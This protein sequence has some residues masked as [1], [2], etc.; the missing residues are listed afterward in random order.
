MMRILL[1]K[2]KLYTEMLV[3]QAIIRHPKR[4]LGFYAIENP[5]VLQ[6]GGSCPDELLHAARLAQDFGYDEINLNLGC[7]SPRVQAGRFGACLMKEK[8][9]VLQCLSH[10]KDHLDIPVTAKT[11][12]GVDECDSYG[13]FEDF[14]DGLV[15]SG[16]DELVVHARK[17]WLKGLNPKQNRIIPPIDYDF[18]YRIKQKHPS[19]PMIING[20]LKTVE[21]MQ[22]QLNY[23]DG[24]MIG[25]LACDNPMLLQR[26]H[27]ILYPHIDLPSRSD[28]LKFYFL[29]ISQEKAHQHSLS[30][31]LKP[32]FNLYHGTIYAK[33]WRQVLQ[34]AIKC[35]NIDSVLDSWQRGL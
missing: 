6:L 17:A 34:N 31:Y 13:F 21:Q 19:L 9:L 30:I 1:P 26:F 32:L 4:Y 12:I 20:D 7:P 11:R 8:Q 28:A 14:I 33:E 2:A 15:A 24:V 27:Q 18:V 16:I 22:N 29:R 35:K 10:L 3:P 23:V 5:L 25:R